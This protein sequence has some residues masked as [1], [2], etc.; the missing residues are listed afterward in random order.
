MNKM[1]V[2]EFTKWLTTKA[3]QFESD[4]KENREINEDDYPEKMYLSDWFEQFSFFTDETE[5][6]GD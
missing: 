2:S 4:W 1:K 5:T 6:D 3:K